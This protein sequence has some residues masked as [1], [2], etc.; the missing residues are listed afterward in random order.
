MLPHGSFLLLLLLAFVICSTAVQDASKA[1]EEDNGVDD[2]TNNDEHVELSKEQQQLQ[3]CRRNP[4]WRFGDRID[5]HSICKRLTNWNPRDYWWRVDTGHIAEWIEDDVWRNMTA[6][7]DQ[8]WHDALAE[9]EDPH[10][11]TK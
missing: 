11:W 2:T 3:E 6:C 4:S 5:Q 10:E 8:R 7:I 9:T 1:S